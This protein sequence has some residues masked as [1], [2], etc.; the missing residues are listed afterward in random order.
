M[1]L[2]TNVDDTINAS[3]Y[4]CKDISRRIMFIAHGFRI[5]T[6]TLQFLELL[7]AYETVDETQHSNQRPTKISSPREIVLQQ[8]FFVCVINV[9]IFNL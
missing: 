4:I 6:L 3:N 9:F 1:T 2:E 5:K 8:Y 7:L